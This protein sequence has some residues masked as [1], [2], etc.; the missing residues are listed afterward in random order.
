MA[1]TTPDQLKPRQ[2]PDNAANFSSEMHIYK[3]ADFYRT[4]DGEMHVDVNI[5]GVPVTL[6]VMNVGEE[7]KVPVWVAYAH[8]KKNAELAAAARKGLYDKLVTYLQP[9]CESLAPGEYVTLMSPPSLKTEELFGALSHDLKKVFGEKLKYVQLIGGMDEKEVAGR[10]TSGIVRPCD[11]VITKAQGK[12]KFIGVTK[13]DAE[14]LKNSTSVIG[15]DDIVNTRE[16]I[17]EMSTVADMVGFRAASSIQYFVIG[18][19]AVWDAPG[20]HYPKKF[21]PNIHA[22]FQIPE[23]VGELPPVRKTG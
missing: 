16:T 3:P 14:I 8:V 1:M 20:L 12:H 2:T 6:P 21:P 17:I 11:S 22:F 9:I 13:E 4:P 10:A 15:V 23:V 5:A 18:T 7:G 19:E